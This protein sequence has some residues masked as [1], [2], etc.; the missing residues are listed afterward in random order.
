M[1]LREYIDSKGY[2]ITDFAKRIDYS[3]RSVSR[4]MAGKNKP[5]PKFKRVVEETT[6]G[7]VKWDEWNEFP[8]LGVK[9]DLDKC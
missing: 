9:D 8:M 1:K 6:K 2:T 4:I 5:G 3:Y 7:K